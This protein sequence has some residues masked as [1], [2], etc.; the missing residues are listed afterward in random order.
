[1]SKPKPGVGYQAGEG[2]D[3][4]TGWGTPVGT[5][6]LLALNDILWLSVIWLR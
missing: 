1:V 6:L 4:V 2:F 3:A 5:S